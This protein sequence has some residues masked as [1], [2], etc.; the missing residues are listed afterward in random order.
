[1]KIFLP[2]AAVLFGGSLLLVDTL[3]AVATPA[4]APKQNTENGPKV[5]WEARAPGVENPGAG[6]G[7]VPGGVPHLAPFR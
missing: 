5:P 2:V 6:A 3:D 7:A 1:M 4:R